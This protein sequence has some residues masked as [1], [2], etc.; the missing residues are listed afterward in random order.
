MAKLAV[1]SDV[2]G[3][4]PALEAVLEDLDKLTLDQCICL[5]D[6]VGYGPFSSECIDLFIERRIP[7]VLGNHDAGV[8]GRL[9]LNHFRDP[10]RK[11]IGIIKRSLGFSQMEWLRNLPLIIKDENWLAVHAEPIRPERWMYVDSAIKARKILTEIDQQLCFV[12]H[13]HI[14]GMVSGQIGVLGF[15]SEYKY[16][17][18]PGSVGQS[19]D[20][21][22]RASYC[23][24]DTDNWEISFKRVSYNTE[25]VLTGLNKLGFSRS[26]SHR[27]LRY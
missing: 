25:K 15:K 26:D 11:L 24:L 1:I 3:N 2:H 13:T 10:N 8:C 7:T 16:L 20:D 22:F 21:D 19:R 17:I 27:L 4:L 9:S 14:P 18:N 6:I 12:G 23:L 5:G